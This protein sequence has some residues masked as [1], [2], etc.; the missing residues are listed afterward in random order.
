M[1]LGGLEAGQQP[2]RP[3]SE[4]GGVWNLQLVVDDLKAVFRLQDFS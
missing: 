3:L 2:H 4:V 1:F